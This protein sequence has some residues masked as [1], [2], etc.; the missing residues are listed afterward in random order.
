MDLLK[1]GRPSCPE[2]RMDIRTVARLSG[3]AGGRGGGEE[4]EEEEEEQEAE[5]EE[6][7]SENEENEEQ[8]KQKEAWEQRKRLTAARVS[9]A[10]TVGTKRVR[11]A[12]Q[13]QAAALA[14]IAQHRQRTVE[15]AVASMRR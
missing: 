8:L 3:G 12:K 4:E 2:C 15:R 11:E 1:H 10:P 7:E 5:E 14:K 13:R 6:Q 9:A